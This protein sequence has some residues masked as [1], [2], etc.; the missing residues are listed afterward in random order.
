MPEM[1][2]IYDFNL[3]PK[4]FLDACSPVELRETE[5]LLSTRLYQRTIRETGI[6]SRLGRN[7]KAMNR[8]EAPL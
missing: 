5:L 4:Q 8:K 3:S 1:H 6:N 7:G 2:K